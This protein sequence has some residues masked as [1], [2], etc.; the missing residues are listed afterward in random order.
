MELKK[1]YWE[2]YKKYL[3][4]MRDAANKIFTGQ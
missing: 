3:T 2:K 1:S 4:T